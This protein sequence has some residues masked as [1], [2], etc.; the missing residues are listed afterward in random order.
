[1]SI[2]QKANRAA[3]VILLR[4]AL[5]KGFEVLLA[6]RPETMPFLGGMYCY[7]GG[8]VRKEDSS[9]TMIDRCFG[10]TPEQARKIM[11]AEFSPG[12]AIGSW[13]A[14]VRELFEEVG[15]LLAVDE[16]GAP[17]IPDS[18][19]AARLAEK[20]AGLLNKS[21]D[22]ISLL[23]SEKLRCDLGS[24]AHFSHWETPA[25]ASIRFDTRFF[26]AAFPGDQTSLSA[27]EE[28]VH[29]LWLTPDRALKLFD[30][31]ELPMIFPT[32]AS[33]RALADYETL[34]S[35]LKDFFEVRRHAIR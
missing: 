7:P 20:H 16:T 23:E 8:S 22:F 28:V 18:V 35:V 4:R 34:E 5:P 24:L 26:L 2:Q 29:S 31:G 17:F 32:F 6:Q 12:E 11:G 30:R 33:L 9:A 13:V 10:L 19:R 21:L 3:T 27:S 14:A 25:Q 15:V 1:M